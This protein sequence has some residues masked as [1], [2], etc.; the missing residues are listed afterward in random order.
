[1]MWFL[2]VSVWLRECFYEAAR[3]CRSGKA[4]HLPWL[5]AGIP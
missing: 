4:A 1:M 2:L 5:W 3:Q